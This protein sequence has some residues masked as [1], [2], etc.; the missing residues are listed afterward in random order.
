MRILHLGNPYFVDDLREFGHEVVHVSFDRTGDVRLDA[1]PVV[2][3]DVLS[4]L[5]PGWGP[6]VVLLG[7]D[8]LFPRVVGLEFLDVPLVWYAID[9]HV[10][11]NWHLHYAPVF[12]VILVAQRDFAR[13]Y[14]TDPDRQVVEWAPLFCDAHVDRRLD[15][16]REIVL[17]L[18]GTLHAKWNPERVRLVE[19]L[20]RRIPLHVQSGPYVETFNR[21]QIV[22]NQSV[23]DDVNFRTFQAM[24]CGALLLT[25]RV[26]NGFA[27]LFQDRRHCVA[28]DRGQ[29]D[30]ILHAVEHFSRNHGER[31]AVAEAGHRLT[32]DSH[33]SRHRVERILH[34]LARYDVSAMVAKRRERLLEI[35]ASVA[36]VYD[37]ACRRCLQAAM[38]HEPGSAV[39]AEIRGLARRYGGLAERIR[40]E[41]DRL[42]DGEPAASMPRAS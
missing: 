19:S 39:F 17:S 8:S 38:R 1:Y 24:A 6:D 33:T 10:H 27:E 3:K 26:G 21:S 22:L 15:L 30:Q 29:I 11:L 25:E 13:C 41:F 2:M 36:S 5:S 34:L 23:A 4:R 42:V 35:E 20:R 9:A 16:P 18:V 7:D 37:L 28:Y 40:A 31:E 14:R 12:D 32:R